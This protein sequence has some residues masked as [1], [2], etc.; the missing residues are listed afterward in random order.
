VTAGGEGDEF[1]LLLETDGTRTLET[2]AGL[3]GLV[4]GVLQEAREKAHHVDFVP[5]QTRKTF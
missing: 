1:L 5:E 2:G 4:G 3:G